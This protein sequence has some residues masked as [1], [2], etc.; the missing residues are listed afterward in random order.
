MDIKNKSD[1][2]TVALM[3]ECVDRKHVLQVDE[4]NVA[5]ITMQVVP[6]GLSPYFTLIGRPQTINDRNTLGEFVVKYCMEEANSVGK[7]VLRN[8]STDG[9]SCETEWNLTTIINYLEGKSNQL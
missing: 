2:Q 1:D 7:S 5:V 8:H 4:V 6:Q 3:E 9:V